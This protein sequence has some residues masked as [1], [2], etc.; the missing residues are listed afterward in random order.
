MS[1]ALPPLRGS[2][3]QVTRTQIS[4]WAA[5]PAAP[6]QPV[7][8]ELLI[9]DVVVGRLQAG[10]FRPDLKRA[11]V[12]EGRHA[13]Q[14]TIPRG[15]SPGRDHSVHL[16]HAGDGRAVPRSPRTLEAD[17][18]AAASGQAALTDAID[19]AA[20]SGDKDAL[21]AALAEQ[22]AALLLRQGTAIPPP[23]AARLAR[24]NPSALPIVPDDGRPQALFIDEGT[25]VAGRD[26]GS[27]AALSHMRA[28]QRL[29]FRVHFVSGYSVE[30]AG[31]RTAALTTLGITCW[32]APWIGSVEEVLRRLGPALAL[33]YVHRFG[34]IQRYGPLIRR[35]CP[36]AR[37]TYC[38][39][40][41]H[42][43]RA[44]RQL[45]I[46]AGEPVDAPI[47]S[48]TAQ[49]MRAA[50]LTAI[51]AADAVITH[52]S[53]EATYLHT[54]VPDAHIHLVPW[55][56]PITPLTSPITTRTGV[57]F[58]GSYG[59]APNLDAA[60]IL[61]ERVMPLVWQQNPA[62]P[63]LLAGSDMPAGLRDAATRVPENRAQALGWVASLDD[64][65][66]RVRMT[67]A[68]LRYGAGLKGKVL[69]SLAA[70]LPCLCSP[71]AAEGMD[72]PPSLQPL[73]GHSEQE[74][75]DIIVRL[76]ADD[77]TCAELSASAQT[78]VGEALSTQRIDILL[79]SAVKG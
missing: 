25:P 26:A 33:V 12:G 16:R 64:V 24:L 51:L 29:G 22:A 34:T 53:Y 44:A 28:L 3:D 14:V 27:S 70:G 8:L 73:I 38:V 76:H 19:A 40:D 46:E 7:E 23:I 13:F 10:L 77:A 60:F 58:V 66:N 43:L 63:L 79:E 69:D 41:L 30:P 11:G 49:G 17:P 36:E 6:G 52:S 35:W 20:A 54:T 15:L 2:L 61:L 42:H 67:A 47:W 57:A 78:W 4:G 56:V 1:D 5:D 71:M 39:A 32:T 75:A 37:L 50:E 68:P 59:H 72:L 21:I 9:D 62:I 65:F 31:E 48:D 45:A 74:M 55:D 18:A